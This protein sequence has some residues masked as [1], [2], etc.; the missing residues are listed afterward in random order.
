MVFHTFHNPSALPRLLHNG[1]PF[2]QPMGKYASK[3][4]LNIGVRVVSFST[5]VQHNIATLYRWLL[6]RV[7]NYKMVVMHNFEVRSYRLNI[8]C[9]CIYCMFM[10]LP[11]GT[12]WLPWLRF[13][14]AFSS[15]VRQMPGYNS[16]RWGTA[17]TLPEVFVLFCVLFVLFHSVYCL[18]VNVYCT[19]ATGWQPNCS[20]TNISCTVWCILSFGW[21]S[22]IW[23]LYAYT[24]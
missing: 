6:F 10:Y 8:V 21:L 17:H 13:F 3:I 5:D 22:S 12:L 7:H 2:Y 14:H 18:C 15:V 23:I 16:Q 24:S 19:T 4:F 11:A 9:L 1:T 20:L